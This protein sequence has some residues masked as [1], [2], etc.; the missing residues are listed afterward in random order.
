MD[1]VKSLSFLICEVFPQSVKKYILFKKAGPVKLR[2]CASLLSG[3]VHNWL[4]NRFSLGLN[5]APCALISFC[6]FPAWCS[7]FKKKSSYIVRFITSFCSLCS[8]SRWGTSVVLEKSWCGSVHNWPELPDSSQITFMTGLSEKSWSGGDHMVAGQSAGC[9]GSCVLWWHTRCLATS[10][11]SIVGHLCYLSCLLP[12]APTACWLA[13][14]QCQKWEM[15]FRLCTCS[16]VLV[17]LYLCVFQV[18][19][20]PVLPSAPTVRVCVLPPWSPPPRDTH[21]SGNFTSG[22]LPSPN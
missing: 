7:V 15:Y 3:T 12:T 21:S 14:P 20:L 6:K 8:G 9:F 18:Y 1:A 17:F 22:C 19:L 2:I 16:Y 4:A 10:V 5:R 13:T 11:L